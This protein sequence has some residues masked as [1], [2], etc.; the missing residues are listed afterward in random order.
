ML[1]PTNPTFIEVIQKLIIL[2]LNQNFYHIEEF[3]DKESNSIIEP[4]VSVTRVKMAQSQPDSNGYSVPNDEGR[5][6]YFNYDSSETKFEN[7][8]LNQQR[9]N[10]AINRNLNLHPL[11]TGNKDR[12]NIMTDQK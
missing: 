11:R 10:E 6:G 5:F 7:R 1:T 9:L 3:Y 12:Y 4:F 2:D 8:N